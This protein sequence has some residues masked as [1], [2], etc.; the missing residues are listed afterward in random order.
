MKINWMACRSTNALQR[1]AEDEWRESIRGLL[2]PVGVRRRVADERPDAAAAPDVGPT[3]CLDGR[4]GIWS[5]ARDPVRVQ[6]V[7]DRITMKTH[8]TS[9]ERSYEEKKLFKVLKPRIFF[10]SMKRRMQQN[11]MKHEK[12]RRKNPKIVFKHIIYVTINSN[13]NF[14]NNDDNNNFNNNECSILW[15][16]TWTVK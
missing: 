7:D 10:S 6:A 15:W 4:F 9:P 8:L 3:D 13:N 14:N 5:K 12:R 16:T 2:V 11:E 1:A